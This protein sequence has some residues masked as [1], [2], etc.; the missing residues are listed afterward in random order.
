MYVCVCNGINERAVHC[1]IDDGAAKV[2]D[3]YR[4]NGCAPRC[5]KCVPLMRETLSARG[6]AEVALDGD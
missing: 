5:G 1:A 4:A 6:V 3:I 2:A